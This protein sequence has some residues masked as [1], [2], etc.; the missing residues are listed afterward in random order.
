VRDARCAIMNTKLA[1]IDTSPALM[2]IAA[3]APLSSEELRALDGAAATARTVPSHREITQEG[4]PNVR[5]TILL[6]GWVYRVRFFSDGRRQILGFALPGDVI[7]VAHQQRALANNTIVTLTPSSLCQ[8]PDPGID[9]DRSGLR[10]AYAV[11]AAVEQLLSYRHI[12]RLGRF[13]AYE[14]IVDWLLEIHERLAAA[15]LAHNG[16]FAFPATQEVVGDALGLTSVHVNRTLQ[17]MRREG[18]LNISGGVARLLDLPRMASVVR[19]SPLQV[20]ADPE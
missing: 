16:T 2:R 8:A 4:A 1:P 12:A 3:L 7:G 13:G 14:R 10:E 11:N 17:L 5:P 15:G 6:A 19:Y 18:L 9:P 20:T